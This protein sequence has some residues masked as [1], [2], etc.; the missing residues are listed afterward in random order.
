MNLLRE[1]QSTLSIDQWNH[2]SNLIHC[3]DEHNALRIV[4]QFIEKQNTLP[5]RLR[6][7]FNDLTDLY[8][9]FLTKVQI[10]ENNEDAHSLCLQDRSILIHTTVKLMASFG[11][12]FLLHQTKILYDPVFFTNNMLLFGTDGMASCKQTASHLDDDMTFVKL[13]MAMSSF[14]TFNYTTF[15][16]TIPKNL[17][18]VKK[19]LRIQNT[20]VDLAWRYMV[21]KHG[22]QHA[23]L[24]FTQLVRCFL[25]FVRATSESD[26]H[27]VY[28]HII[29]TVGEQ[30]EQALVLAHR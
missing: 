25:Y 16:N 1:D 10:F 13:I 30:I 6:Y 17:I 26:E 28:T 4:Q 24:R 11:G 5:I 7:K 3:F 9:S 20:Y 22:Y 19:V 14:S 21:Y 29:D 23:I 15:Q 2:I 18:D 27:Q 8:K 12:L